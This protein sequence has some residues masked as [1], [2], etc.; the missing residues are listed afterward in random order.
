MSRTNPAIRTLRTLRHTSHRTTLVRPNDITKNLSLLSNAT[1]NDAMIPDIVRTIASIDKKS[2]ITTNILHSHQTSEGTHLHEDIRQF[3]PA[4]LEIDHQNR[5]IIVQNTNI[6][7]LTD[8]IILF[9]RYLPFE[10][11]FGQGRRRR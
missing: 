7:A 2:I 1:M 4:I 11:I 5:P 6:L 9:A 8:A 10:R 3:E